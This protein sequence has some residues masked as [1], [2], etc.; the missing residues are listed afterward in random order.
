MSGAARG[1][2]DRLPLHQE[3]YLLAHDRS[4]KLLVHRTSMALGLAGAVL[5]ELVLS[6]RVTFIEGRATVTDRTPI[7]DAVADG[8][9]PLI[10]REHASRDLKFWIKRVAEDVYDRTCGC[11]TAEG[12]LTRVTKR[13]MGMLPARTRFQL[14]DMASV[15]RASSGVRSA[16]EGLKP[17]DARCAALCGLLGVL[18]VDSE[19]Y[20]LQ[21][22][23]QVIGRLNAI[24]RASSPVVR[25]VVGVVDTFIAEAAVAIYR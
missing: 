15:V 25:E 7:G 2:Q 19:L 24:A 23:G 12:V 21:P 18:R 13:P 8:I 20:L 9:L 5:L 16:V 17:P 1:P 4:G 11:L 14:S 10:L 22:S 3:L 6:E